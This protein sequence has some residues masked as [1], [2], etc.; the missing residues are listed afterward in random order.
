M[1]TQCVTDRE[2]EFKNLVASLV[3]QGSA[4]KVYVSGWVTKNNVV[5]G[6]AY[7]VAMGCL[8]ELRSYDHMYKKNK[9]SAFA[10]YY[11][12]SKSHP[13]EWP[14]L[15]IIN[16]IGQAAGIPNLARNLEVVWL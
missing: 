11:W 7:V 4:A 10:G 6:R 16:K 15:T 5:W 12:K 13:G 2:Q 9:N 1:T 8:V 3:K 14:R